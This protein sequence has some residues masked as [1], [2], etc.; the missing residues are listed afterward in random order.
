MKKGIV[1]GALG[2]LFL[3]GPAMAADAPKSYSKCKI[4][5][6]MPG[7]VGKIGPD[8][9]QSA[10]SEADFIKQTIEGSKWEGRQAKM[11]GFESKTMPKQKVTEAEAKEIFHFAT[12][13]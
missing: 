10:M 8:L 12:G 1:I 11:A 3:A 4:C 13:K 7:E 5:H 9:A 6:G 2:A